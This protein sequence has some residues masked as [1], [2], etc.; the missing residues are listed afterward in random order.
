MRAEILPL[1]HVCSEWNVRVLTI[2]IKMH[3]V[4]Q[5]PC[6][7]HVTETDRQSRRDRER[8]SVTV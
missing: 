5:S 7:Y 3:A 6:H 1:Y 8:K 4:G 2:Q